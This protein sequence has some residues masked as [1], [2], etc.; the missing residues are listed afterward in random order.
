[1]NNLAYSSQKPEN[2]A[3]KVEEIVRK[4]MGVNEALPYTVE[5]IGAPK[6]G[7]LNAIFKDSASFL[8]GGKETK[9]F[10]FTFDFQ[11]PRN[12]QLNIQINR[13]GI[14]CHAGSLVFS[15]FINKPIKG[16]ITMEG[17][18]TFG[19][20]KFTGDT[21]AIAKLNS[22]K[23]LLKLADKFARTKSDI[24]GGIKMDRYFRMEPYNNGAT[25]VI[26]TLPRATSMG[27]S[28]TT[29]AKD[30]FTIAGLVEATL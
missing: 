2:V 15:T 30:F 14:G 7:A 10:N 18:K 26:I 27:I 17:P 28:A 29:D 11:Q 24:G 21:D 8:F 19:T 6:D 16:T 25:L 1:M 9:L 13:Q 22:N 3:P 12:V 20:S 23:D 4:D 5:E